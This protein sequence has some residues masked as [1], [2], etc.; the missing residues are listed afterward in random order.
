MTEVQHS[1]FVVKHLERQGYGDSVSQW[2]RE[3]GSRW[4][5]QI[6][7]QVQHSQFVVKRPERHGK[8]DS[9]PCGLGKFGFRWRNRGYCIVH[10]AHPE[11]CAQVK[12]KKQHL[13]HSSGTCTFNINI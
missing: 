3:F 1:Q 8:G 6:S 12:E 13:C 2:V 9:V 7:S 4:R 5:S 10:A 11:S